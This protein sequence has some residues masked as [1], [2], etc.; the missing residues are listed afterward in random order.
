VKVARVPVQRHDV[1]DLREL[2][3]ALDD[4]DA[5]LSTDERWALI[6]GALPDEARAAAALNAILRRA[7]GTWEL[8]REG[9]E[10][11]LA[12]FSPAGDQDEAL[13][14]AVS[15]ARLVTIDGWRRLKRCRRCDTPFLD[16]TNGAT[17]AACAAHLSH[18]G[19]P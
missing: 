11:R 3:A 1:R 13:E 2:R 14:A 16:T 6:A 9:S 7:C 8:R 18:R 15:L 4:I 12:P 19:G 5:L 10:W 17:R